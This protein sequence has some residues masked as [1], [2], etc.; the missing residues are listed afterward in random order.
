M[1][2]Q[3]RLKDDNF[4]QA[5]QDKFDGIQRWRERWRLNYDTMRDD[6]I[7][8]LSLHWYLKSCGNSPFEEVTIGWVGSYPFDKLYYT[9]RGRKGC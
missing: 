6:R 9:Y 1:D 2:K 5:L 8:A 3:D 7:L 4:R